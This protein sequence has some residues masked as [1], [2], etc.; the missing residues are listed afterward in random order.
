MSKIQW[1]GSTWNPI[2]GCSIPTLQ[3]T[4]KPRSGCKNCYAPKDAPHRFASN[5]DR[6]DVVLIRGK[7]TRAGLT[8]VPRTPEGKSL[9][10]GAQWT[11]EIRLLPWALDVPLRRRKPETYFVNSLSDLFHESIVDCAEGR[12]FIAAIFGVMAACPQHTFQILTKRPHKAREW[13]AWLDGMADRAANLFGDDPMDWRR[14]H[15]ARAALGK[16]LKKINIGALAMADAWPLR[17]V[18]IGTSVEDQ[19][20]ADWAIPELLK[21]PASL[22]FLSAE[23]LL[24]PVQL[25]RPIPANHEA[26]HGHDGWDW[27]RPLDGRG[28]DSQADFVSEAPVFV[29]IDWVI[30]GGESGANARPCETEWIRSLVGQCLDAGVPAFVKQLGARPIDHE[31]G[32]SAYLLEFADKKGGDIEEW[33]DDLRIRM[34]PR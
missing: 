4:G 9:G 16:V 8:Y 33:D 19:A 31:P 32:G 20:S 17:N 18:W 23:P 24:G 28:W 5:Y 22:R 7:A 12:R 14:G 10:K 3:S 21:V 15:V 6:D 13:F 30:V 2:V 26:L 27:A 29:S 11:G 1:T 25:S 34:M